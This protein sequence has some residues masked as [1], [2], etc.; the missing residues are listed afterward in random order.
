MER[1]NPDQSSANNEDLIDSSLTKEGIER[2]NQTSEY[3]TK[4]LIPCEAGIKNQNP[5]NTNVNETS[6]RLNIEDIFTTIE[7]TLPKEE[8]LKDSLFPHPRNWL[9]ARFLSIWVL[10]IIIINKIRKLI[11]SLNPIREYSEEIYSIKKSETIY[12]ASKEV[13][14]GNS[15][16]RF[17]GARFLTIWV[18]PLA[19]TGAVM[20]FLFISPITGAKPFG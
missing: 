7:R 15:P 5:S 13:F 2:V 20:E 19:I 18:L 4:E 16:M 6:Q 17:F 9:G 12:T 1:K 10:P 11:S 14:Q 3:S 8:S